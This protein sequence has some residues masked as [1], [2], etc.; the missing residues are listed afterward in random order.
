MGEGEEEVELRYAAVC[1]DRLASDES[2]HGLVVPDSQLEEISAE[3]CCIVRAKHQWRSLGSEKTCTIEFEVWSPS[4][5]SG[6]WS[7]S[8]EFW[9][10]AC[11]YS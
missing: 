2:C 9:T 6:V 3:T 10:K 11:L 7:L 4:L 1:D 5:E 8:T